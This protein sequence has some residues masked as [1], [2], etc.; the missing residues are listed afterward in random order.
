[1]WLF[2]CL[3]EE[4]GDAVLQANTNPAPKDMSEQAHLL[5]IMSL[6]V[7]KESKLVQRIKLGRTSQPIGIPIRNHLAALKGMARQCEYTI[8]CTHCTTLVDFSR[9][10][11]VLEAETGPPTTEVAGR[12]CGHRLLPPHHVQGEASRTKTLIRRIFF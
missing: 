6:A 8:Q 9:N 10:G 1:M 7:K 4:L 2:N 12:N 11:R 3:D 5:S